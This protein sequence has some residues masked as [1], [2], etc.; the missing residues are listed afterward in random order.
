MIILS[1]KAQDMILRIGNGNGL[2]R[3][4]VQSGGCSGM[5]YEASIIPE[6]ETEDKTIYSKDSITVV[7]D[8][9]S[10]PYIDGLEVDYSNDLISAGFRFMNSKNNSSCG[11]GGS[12][13]VSGL[14]PVILSGGAC[15]D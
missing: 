1:K 15:H 4:S 11:C 2:V 13:S 5:T 12:F 10:L 3:I 6:R 14:P 8:D 9:F 7:T